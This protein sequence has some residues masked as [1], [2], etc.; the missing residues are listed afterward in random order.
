MIC[1]VDNTQVRKIEDAPGQRGG[2]VID[3]R[4]DGDWLD[5]ISYAAAL[6]ATG[7]AVFVLRSGAG[8]VQ[9]LTIG[10]VPSFAANWSTSLVTLPT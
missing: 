9:H 10:I 4:V 7:D 2:D 3:T 5:T 1:G 8:Q 6:Y